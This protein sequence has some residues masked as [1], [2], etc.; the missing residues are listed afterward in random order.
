MVASAG[1]SIGRLLDALGDVINQVPMGGLTRTAEVSRLVIHDPDGRDDPAGDALVLIIGQR[2]T[3]EIAELIGTL[4]SRGVRIIAIRSVVPLDP[5][6]TAVAESAGVTLLVLAASVSWTQLIVL[7]QTL[8]AAVPAEGAMCVA[9]FEAANDLFSFADSVSALVDAPI[10][11]EDAEFQVLAFSRRQAATDQARI[12]TVLDRKVPSGY[13]AML[14]RSGVVQHLRTSAEPVWVPAGA[15]ESELARIAIAIRS[16]DRYLGSMWAAV[17]APLTPERECALREAANM[18]GLHLV[19]RQSLEEVE[20]RIHAERVEALLCGEYPEEAAKQLDLASG[21]AVVLAVGFVTDSREPD[22]DARLIALSEALAVH[23]RAVQPKSAVAH[24]D[25]AVYAILA[26]RKR[27]ADAVAYARAVAG[28]FL[29]RIGHRFRVVAG[30]GRAAARPEDLS[31][32]RRDAERALGV[33]KRARG[34]QRVATFEDVYVDHALRTI[35]ET[36]R[37]EGLDP[38]GAIRMPS[39]LDQQY[40]DT[41]FEWLEAFG[42]I[43]K[44]SAALH[45]HQNTFRYRLRRVREVMQLDLDD[46]D[47]RFRLLVQLR[48]AKCMDCTGAADSE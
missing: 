43:S 13:V 36:A 34:D 19:Q 45:V 39:K 16:G 46:P 31:R 38:L 18:L 21:S 7:L 26:T 23:L 9:G 42:D 8:L 44:A 33:L 28:D 20:R 4:G 15:V 41:L 6:I 48:I 12:A 5:K 37:G 1:I 24:I 11:I 27:E 3:A 47:V 32:G 30:I 17:S 2:S 10:T 40:M 35:S 22:G 25:G 29:K 14:E